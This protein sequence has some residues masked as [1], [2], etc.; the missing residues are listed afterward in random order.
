MPVLIYTAEMPIF[1][2]IAE[3]IF[4]TEKW[5]DMRRSNMM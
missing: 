2:Y 4:V 3:N 1:M 5:Y